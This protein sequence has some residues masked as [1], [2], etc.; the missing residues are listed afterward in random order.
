MSS[1]VLARSEE[2]L[3]VTSTSGEWYNF[4][5]NFT[6]QGNTTYWFGYFSDGFTRNFYDQQANHASLIS[7]GN[8]LPDSFSGSFTYSK[9]NIM[10]LYGLYTPKDLTLPQPTSQPPAT[11][12]L[13]PADLIAAIC[14]SSATAAAT[15]VFIILRQKKLRRIRLVY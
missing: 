1:Q 14:V 12:S 11:D 9:S 4:T 8:T 13:L 3:N 2:T 6:P 10:S 7:S 5:L 15:A